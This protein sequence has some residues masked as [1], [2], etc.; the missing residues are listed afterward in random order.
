MRLESFSCAGPGAWPASRPVSAQLQTPKKKGAGL[1][2][3]NGRGSLG[4][5]LPFQGLTSPPPRALNRRDRP[6]LGRDARSVI[7]IVPGPAS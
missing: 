1:C 6:Y 2:S 5:C 3:L 7:S 4:L